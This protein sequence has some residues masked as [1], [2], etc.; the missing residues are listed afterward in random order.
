MGL[1]KTDDEMDALFE[2][3]IAIEKYYWPLYRALG[4]H[5]DYSAM[6]GKP[7]QLEA[8]ARHAVELTQ[9]KEGQILYL[10]IARECDWDVIC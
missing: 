7:G 9:Q 3:G 1:G 2:K 6:G 4:L 5:C 8:F 10:I